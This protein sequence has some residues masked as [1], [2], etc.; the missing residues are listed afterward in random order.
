MLLAQ[1]LERLVLNPGL[2]LRLGT[3][4]RTWA[5]ECSYDA[6]MRQLAPLATG[7]FSVLSNLT[8]EI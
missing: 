1:T 6:R 2:A 3:N 5:V 8:R 4:A 7:D